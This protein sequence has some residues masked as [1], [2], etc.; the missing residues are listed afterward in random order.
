[1]TEA[2]AVSAVQGVADANFTAAITEEYS[3]TVGVGYVISQTPAADSD[4]LADT[5]VSIVISKGLDP[6]PYTVKSTVKADVYSNFYLIS[7]DDPNDPSIGAQGGQSYINVSARDALI[8]SWAA[9]RIDVSGVKAELNGTYGEGNWEIIDLNLILTHSP[10][11]SFDGDIDLLWTSDDLTDLS[12][13]MSLS[14]G[15]SSQIGGQFA[16]D[17]V[18]TNGRLIDTYDYDADIPKNDENKYALYDEDATVNSLQTT[19]FDDFMNDDVMTFAIEDNAGSSPAAGWYGSGNTSLYPRLDVRIRSFIV[20][21]TCDAPPTYDTNDD[22]VIDFADFV[23][24]ASEWLYCG[25][26]D[27]L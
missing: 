27:C 5:E 21:V 1:M 20:P 12:T 16:L 2:D 4:V 7:G 14:D 23:A 22:C 26:S 24:Y 6:D 19:L 15:S 17:S 8:P 13:L 25:L 10:Y 9:V 11:N 18:N 3:S